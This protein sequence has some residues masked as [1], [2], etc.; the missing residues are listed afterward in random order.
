MRGFLFLVVGE[1]RRVDVDDGAV[2]YLSGRCLVRL[3][4]VDGLEHGR[5]LRALRFGDL[6]QRVA[7][8]VHRAALVSGIR[9]HLG[10]RADHAGGLVADDYE[11]AAQSSRLQPR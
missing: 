1:G 4:R 9:E 2:G 3:H 10:D 5:D 11:N 7:V 6:C 8:E